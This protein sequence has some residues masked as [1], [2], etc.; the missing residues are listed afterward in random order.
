MSRAFISEEAEAAKAAERPERPVTPGP[1][2][3][4]PAGH[5]QILAEVARLRAAGPEAQRDLRY[6]LARAA[7]AQ[8]VPPPEA[9]TEAAFNTR[10]TLDNG[11]VWY[12]VGEDE[13]DPAQGRLN[14]ASPLAQALLGARPGE[15]A[16]LPGR[17]AFT[18]TAVSPG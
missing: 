4:T 2:P 9:P 15:T 7:S 16:A 8:S 17:P 12:I 3:V 11:A 10:V 1:N 18:I 14:W 6:W 13:A 5:A